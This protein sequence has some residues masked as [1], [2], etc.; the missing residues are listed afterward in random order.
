VGA[1]RTAAAL[2]L[3]LATVTG[4]GLGDGPEQRAAPEPAPA[5]TSA[6]ADEASAGHAG[7]AGAPANLASRPLRAG[8][9][10]LTLTMPAAYTPSAPNGV[11]TD[12]YRC[13]LLDPKLRRD[14]FLTGTHVIPGNRDVVHHVILFRV[15]PGQVGAAHALDDQDEDPGWTCFGGT[16]L[17]DF[18]N[19]D[20]AEWL[21]AWAPGGRE[22]V[23]RRGLG[24]RL[25][26]GSQIVMQV[27][28]NLLAGDAPDVSATQLRLARPG[29]RLTGL[30]TMLLPAPVELPCRPGHDSAPLCDRDAALADV[31]QRFGDRAG[32]TADLLHFLCGTRPRPGNTQ[33]CTRTLSE[34]MTIHGV[35]GHMHL[36]G[37]SIRI[38]VNPGT[39]RARTVLDVPVWDFDNQGAVP[40][41]PVRLDTW[42]TVKVT[43]RHVQWLRDK[44]PAFEGQ[45][46]RYVVWGEGTT[47][48]M[49][50][51]ILQVTRP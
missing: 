29:A 37:R 9:Q 46:E 50:L 42:D 35:A 5:T 31:K 39:D 22:S 49:C 51:G 32:A 8:E 28:Y 26:A 3:L 38:E 2:A 45:D 20:D 30:G 40:I 1:R 21:G 24:V 13:F 6:G 14:R 10:R 27:H 25:D 36:L 11:G 48:E 41:D 16:G 15:R 19:V 33:S 47:D 44:L 12:D 18:T 34:P 7:H 4:C 17:D 23:H 43:C